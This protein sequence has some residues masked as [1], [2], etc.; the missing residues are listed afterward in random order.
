MCGRAADG[1]ERGHRTPAD[2]CEEV[3]MRGISLLVLGALIAS[4]TAAPPPAVTTAQESTAA[5]LLAGKVAGP[6]VNCISEFRANDMRWLDSNTVAFKASGNRVYVNHFEGGCD[7]Y[8]E[9]YALVTRQVA[10][11]QLCRGDIAGLVDPVSH[12]RA[13]SCVF[14]D[15]IPYTGPGR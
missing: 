14:G 6:P 8:G 3:I 1:G 9:R 10:T 2:E 12:Y 15:F 4:C 5:R 13:G 11:A 7:N